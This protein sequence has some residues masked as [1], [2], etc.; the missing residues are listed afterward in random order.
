MLKEAAN[1]CPAFSSVWLV[2]I[3]FL[4]F[5]MGIVF[6]A[7]S[8]WGITQA[9]SDPIAAALPAAALN[10]IVASGVFLIILAIVGWVGVGLNYKIGGRVVLGFYIFILCLLM[11]MQVIAAGVCIT[12][13]NELDDDKNALLVRE[14][15]IYAFINNSYTACCCGALRCPND[16]CWIPS[17]VPYRCDTFEVFQISLHDYIQDKIVPVAAIAI[18]IA[19]VELFTAITACCNICKGVQKEEKRRIGGPPTY[20][21]V[22]GEGEEAY[23]ASAYE[24][25]VKTGSARPGSTAAAGAPTGAAAPTAGG[26]PTGPSGAPK[27]GRAPANAAAKR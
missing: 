4:Y 5:I 16:T 1:R 25:Y 23:S 3:N 15:T 8:S 2:G 26:A 14:Y 7:L 6:I 22:Y 9:A 10:T 12:F 13:T 19:F 21:G 27:P 24:S 11:L 18:V 17:T 20:D